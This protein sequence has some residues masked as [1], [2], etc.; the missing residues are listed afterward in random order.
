M[1]QQSNGAAATERPSIF[2]LAFPSILGNLL[3]AIVGMVQTKAVSTLGAQALAATG[4]GQRVFFALQ[5]VMMAIGAGTTAL[6][7]RAWGANDHTE[8]SRVTMASL[9]LSCVL[10]I[11]LTVPGLLVARPVASIFG[12]DEHTLDL[13][14]E[15]IRWLA[16]FN[17]A[18]AVNFIMASALRAT[19][20]AWTPLVVGAL[21]NVVNIP[22]LYMFVFGNWGAPAMGVAGAAL[23]AGL[24]FTVGMVVLLFL[25][26]R[27]KLRVTHQRGGWFRRERLKRLL[28]IGYPAA[29]E[30]LIFQAGFFGFLTLIGR[31]YGTEAFAAY[32][33]GVNLLNICMVVGFGFS[34]A[35]AT[36]TGQFL[37]ANDPD[38]AVRSAWRATG[39][40]AASMGAL[41]LVVIAFANELAAFFL[42]DDE[43]TI[44][45]T[46]E[47]TWLLGLMMPLMAVEF[48]IGGALRGAGDT[49]FPL[50]AT[51]FGLIGMRCG[52]AALFTWMGW[53]VVWVY[54]ALVGDYVLKNAMLTLRF[55]SGRWKY[56]IRN[57]EL[58]F[59]RT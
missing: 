28:G 40:A 13:A 7:A 37:G 2:Q 9:V 19:G 18:Y 50:V 5:A 6:V 1:S 29:V 46:V 42:G 35:G 45:H 59:A 26:F 24:A 41:G 53:P 43:V 48:T 23:A 14:A 31:F 38:G 56:I 36:L 11:A 27:G 16:A 34:I 44:R 8:A 21:V 33:I 55:R 52:L 25:W 49:R 10:A 15:N 57:E 20:D 22:L 17:L 54:A 4:A 12:L 3:Y 51:F 30:Q 39:L 58:D 47:F 32:N